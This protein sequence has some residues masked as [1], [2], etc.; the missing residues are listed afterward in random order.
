MNKKM[1]GMMVGLMMISVTSI[2]I[3]EAIKDN[4]IDIITA[5]NQAP[6]APAILNDRCEMTDRGYKLTFSITDPEGD[7]VYYNI[8]WDDKMAAC[9]PDKAW[10]G[11]FESGE[12]IVAYHNWE[13]NGEYTITLLAKDN[14]NLISIETTHIVDYKKAKIFENPIFNQLFEQILKIFPALRSFI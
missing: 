2:A 6:E 10:I 8:I 4:P 14:N 11:P 13:S 5:N 1:I 3:G 7:P 12:E 9:G